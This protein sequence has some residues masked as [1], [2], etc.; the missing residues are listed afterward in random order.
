M[1]FTILNHKNAKHENPRKEKTSTP[2]QI[3]KSKKNGI[4]R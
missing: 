2:K 3:K 4:F 1:R